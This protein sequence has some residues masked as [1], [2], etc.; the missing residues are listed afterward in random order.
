MAVAQ[1][2]REIVEDPVARRLDFADQLLHQRVVVIGEA[3]QHRIARLLL[4][5]RDAG[6]HFDDLEGRVLAIDERRAR[7][8]DR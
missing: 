6:G 2:L 4:I 5:G 1:L 3:L 7:E 8:P